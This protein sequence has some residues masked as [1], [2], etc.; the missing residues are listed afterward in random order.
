MKRT[1]LFLF[2]VALLFTSCSKDDVNTQDTTLIGTWKLSANELTSGLDTNNDGVTSLN[3]VEENAIIEATLTLDTATTGTFFYN[4]S[5]SFNTRSEDHN[6]I[7]LITSTI[8]SEN[9]PK[10]FNYNSDDEYVDAEVDITFNKMG[11]ITESNYESFLNEVPKFQE[12]YRAKVKDNTLLIADAKSG[13]VTSKINL[14]NPTLAKQTLA[15]LAGVSGYRGQ[16]YDAKSLI[17][18]YSN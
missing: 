7:F 13:K 10:Q 16:T 15:N 18:Q 14:S 1:I 12:K 11:N 8:T 5:V 17:A 4:S 2:T 3:L 6:M 9:V